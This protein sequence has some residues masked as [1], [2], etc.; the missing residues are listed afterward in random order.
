MFKLG[1][2]VMTREISN[3]IDRSDEFLVFVAESF[4]RYVMKDWGDLCK[5]DKELNDAAIKNED[6]RILASYRIPE[7]IDLDLPDDRIWIITEWDRSYTTVL[8]PYEY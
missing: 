8:F 4:K 1:E 2:T 6:S 3:A 5:E 7:N